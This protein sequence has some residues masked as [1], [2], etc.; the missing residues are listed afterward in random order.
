MTNPSRATAAVGDT[1]RTPDPTDHWARGIAA[2]AALLDASRHRIHDEVPVHD[3]RSAL[4]A[5][6]AFIVAMTVWIVVAP[7]SSVPLGWFAACVVAYGAAG[8]VEFEIGPGCALPTAPVQVVTLFLLPPELVPLAVVAG[9][10][11]AAGLGRL[12]DRRRR[13]RPLVLVASAWQ[14]V[15]PAA[16]FAIAH[17]HGTQLSDWPVFVGALA[18]QFA[19]DSAAAWLR[20]CYGLA[21]PLEQLAPALGF[22]F[23]CDGFLAPIG[24]AAVLAV[25]RSPGAFLFLLPPTALL[26][27]LQ[28]DRRR[29]IDKMVALGAAFIDST[30]LARRDALTGVA[31]RLAFEEVTARYK[32]MEAALGV[33]LADVDG[34]KW[35]ND[36]L[37]H[38]TG[39]KLLVAV[40]TTLQRATSWESGAVVFRIGGDEFAI[41]LPENT[42]ESTAEIGAA[43][44]AAFRS[45]SHGHDGVPISASIG[46]GY[47]A[48]GRDLGAA[49]AA[50]DRGVHIDKDARGVRRR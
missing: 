36:T 25:P 19:F 5:A 50:A 29:H 47:A 33:I 3:R 38:A 35:A 15:G 16:V 27:M 45:T 1:A 40:A 26:A 30:G 13:E 11:A 32:R 12:R 44:R 21:V 34:L 4:F 9:L 43:L 7:P 49:I 23:L 28:S 42:P 2:E 31:N 20:N 18:S 37:G 17:V 10:F 6:G 39:D 22:T 46:V 14:V 24:L 41:L 48:T 8:A